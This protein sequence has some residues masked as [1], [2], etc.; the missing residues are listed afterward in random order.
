MSVTGIELDGLLYDA[1]LTRR[2]DLDPDPDPTPGGRQLSVYLKLWRRSSGPTVAG[3]AK[4][5]ITEVRLSFLQGRPLALVGW[6][7][8]DEAGVARDCAALRERGVAVTGSIGGEAGSVTTSDRQA[9][10]SGIGALDAQIGLDRID[11]D[12][13][14][15][16]LR[17]DDVLAI[18]Q[19][20]H[21]RWGIMTTM[22]PNGSN[23]SQYLPVAVEL[24]KRGLLAAYGQQFY[25]SSQGVTVGAAMDRIVQSVGAGI[26]A[27]LTQVGMWVGTTAKQWT[28]SQCEANLR[29]I[30]GRWSDIGG[31]YLWS[32]GH[33]EVA[34]WAARMGA[35]LA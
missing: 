31:A 33:G 1:V 3:A 9:C 8:Q 32:E 28:M 29:T 2:T 25:G 5:G 21:D 20:A 19:A 7:S 34:E 35:A 16:A 13:E 10:L 18:S 26:P 22:A 24:H 6:G 11:W 27:R 4:P 23:V 14:A 12:V 30:R 17:A 15:A